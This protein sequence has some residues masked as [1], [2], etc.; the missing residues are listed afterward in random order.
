M[1]L[2]K[3]IELENGIILNYHRI[4]AFNKITKVSNIIEINSKI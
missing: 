1:A 3:G 4:A 2:G